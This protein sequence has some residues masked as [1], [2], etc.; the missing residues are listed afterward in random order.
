MA[1]IQIEP[2]AQQKLAILNVERLACLLRAT[3]GTDQS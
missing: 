2:D 1:L 3:Y